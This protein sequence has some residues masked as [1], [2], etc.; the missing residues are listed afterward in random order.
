[1]NGLERA[2]DLVAEARRGVALTGAGVSAES[3]IPTFR[4]QNGL[5]KQY[6]PVKVSSIEHFLED[7]A[8]YWQGSRERW[9]TYQQAR[10]NPG[11]RA[12]A[13]LESI[14]NLAAV[15]T[16]N[17]DNLH[18]EA[19]SRRLIELHGNGLTVRC[20]ECGASEPR[21]DVQAR[22]EVE[23][24]P[25]CRRCGGSRIKP[26][27]VFFGESMPAAATAEAFDLAQSC[28]LMLVVGSSLTVRPAADVPALAVRHGAPL[29]VLNDEPTPMD[30]LAEVVL[31]GRSGEILPELLRRARPGNGSAPPPQGG[32]PSS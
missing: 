7:P 14:G 19:G 12:L 32:R 30:E 22:L 20:L 24:P 16:Q 11:H 8:F 15:V 25:R 3:G 23:M 27:V 6:D 28:D 1:M 5:W 31:R 21:A 2:A 13:E 17:T 4:G 18:R 9:A 10:P 26:A 29:L